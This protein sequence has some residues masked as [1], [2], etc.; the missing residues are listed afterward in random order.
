MTNNELENTYDVLF[1]NK[2]TNPVDLP[3][4]HP[5]EPIERGF[6][7]IQCDKFYFDKNFSELFNLKQN[8]LDGIYCF[9]SKNCE[10]TLN[11][12]RKFCGVSFKREA[13]KEI[14]SAAIKQKWQS[15]GLTFAEIDKQ[16]NLLVL[17]TGENID[18]NGVEAL[19]YEIVKKKKN[20]KTSNQ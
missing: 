20:R 10:L 11:D 13:G 16:Q 9:L 7:Y 15:M 19:E 2:I 6:L 14:I 1:Q 17:S 5:D 8:E 18:L 3:G 4:N 12:G